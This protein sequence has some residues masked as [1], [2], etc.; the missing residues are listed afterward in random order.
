MVHVHLHVGWKLETLIILLNSQSLD[1]ACK[2]RHILPTLFSPEHVQWIVFLTGNLFSC[3]TYL[4]NKFLTMWFDYS[5]WFSLL[6]TCLTTEGPL[7]NLESNWKQFLRT[8]YKIPPFFLL[9][10]QFPIVLS[11][12]LR[13]LPCLQCTSQISLGWKEEYCLQYRA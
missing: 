6:L 12:W 8:R 4:S 2:N 9:S 7:Q 1:V 11:K 5:P 10:A 3:N 13:Q